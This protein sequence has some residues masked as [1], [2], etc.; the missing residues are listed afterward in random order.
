MLTLEAGYTYAVV[1]CLP[2]Q[3][4]S[5]NDLIPIVLNDPFERKLPQGKGYLRLRDLETGRHQLVRLSEK[6]RFL[7]SEHLRARRRELI[8]QFYQYGLDF[9]EIHTNEPF[10]ELITSLFLL[11]RR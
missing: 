6:N 10:Y 4:A 5:K 11:R 8:Q 2:E 1:P 7:Y 3:I 9:Q